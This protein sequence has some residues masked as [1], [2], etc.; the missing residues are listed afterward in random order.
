MRVESKGADTYRL[1][2]EV[3]RTEGR[4]HQKTETFHGTRRA[5]ERRW[6]EIQRQIDEG[7]IGPPQRW[8]WADA[9][10]RWM[11]DVLPMRG[12]KASTIHH[13]HTM[14][15]VYLHPLARVRL[16]QTTPDDLQQLVA[17]L[18]VSG[19]RDGGPLSPSVLRELRALLHQL[20]DLSVRWGW[21]TQ[22][23]VRYLEI[24][25]GPRRPPTVWD[26]EDAR[27]FF[28]TVG[29]HRLFAL[30]YTAVATGM[31]SGE[32]LALPWDHVL[33]DAHRILV[34][35]ALIR[36]DHGNVIDRTKSD[37]SQRWVPLTASCATVLHAHQDHLAVER[38]KTRRYEDRG[39]VFPSTRGTL[40]DPRN[41]LRDFR[42]FQ[43][44]SHVPIIRFH[45]LRH[46]HA[47]WLLAE[48]KPI[49]LIRDQLG[50]RSSA[51][52]ADIY[53]HVLDATHYDALDQLDHQVLEGLLP[54][55]VSPKVSPTRG[56]SADTNPQN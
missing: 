38:K 1:F 3:G 51:F 50:H 12:R 30:F 32:L 54:P 2:W 26:A 48:G 44:E 15:E 29:D 53:A 35:Q 55:E 36:T 40:L 33:W 9:W 24:P 34:T 31:R 6:R 10:T 52:T 4:R 41:V 13:Y 27:Q 20:G 21:V 56:V 22:N 47:T 18:G 25:E 42:R 43:E 5:A 17:S 46:T 39:L 23:P 45:D 11:R 49:E 37:R 8:T 16:D 14:V 28:R 19:R 7:L